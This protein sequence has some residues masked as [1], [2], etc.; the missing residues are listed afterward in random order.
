MKF[1]WISKKGKITDNNHNQ[2]QSGNKHERILVAKDKKREKILS[3]YS[4]KYKPT[5]II[6]GVVTI[7]FTVVTGYVI[8]KSRSGD[9]ISNSSQKDLLQPPA[10]SGSVANLVQKYSKDYGVTGEKV[11][12][13]NP[14]AWNREVLDEAYFTL[15]YA[16]KIG[17]FSR[18][19]STLLMIELAKR[20]G[21]DIDDNSYGIDKKMRDTIRKRADE[22]ANNV[23]NKKHM[24]ATD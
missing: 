1:K 22:V 13:S 24:E 5:L 10:D 23:L 18:V 9:S 7:L 21:L 11:K 3:N 8:V 16:D 4:V 17:D 6:L 2:D 20:N 14:S 19:H 15:L 12:R